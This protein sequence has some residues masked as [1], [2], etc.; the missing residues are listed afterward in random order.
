MYRIE[1]RKCRDHDW[2]LYEVHDNKQDA[3][4]VVR[5]LRRV[6]HESRLIEP[7][8]NDYARGMVSKW[9]DRSKGHSGPCSGNLT[10]PDVARKG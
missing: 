5:D 8:G 10:A 4:S 2:H 1:W 3:Q 6:G 7:C 9:C